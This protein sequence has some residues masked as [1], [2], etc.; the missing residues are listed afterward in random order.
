MSHKTLQHAFVLMYGASVHT[1][2]ALGALLWEDAALTPPSTY[3]RFR[4][5]P[6][7]LSPACRLYRDS[8]AGGEAGWPDLLRAR[9]TDVLLRLFVD[10][11]VL[12]L[13]AFI[14]ACRYFLGVYT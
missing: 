2:V 1:T 4:V 8:H 13:G 5:S 10:E 9:E 7:Y 6:S 14:P 3:A 11:A 12:T